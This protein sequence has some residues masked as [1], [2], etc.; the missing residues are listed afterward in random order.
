MFRLKLVLRL[1]FV[2]AL[3]AGILFGSA[4]RLDL[5]FF[6]AYL[7]VFAALGAVTLLTLRQDLLE[8]RFNRRARGRDNLAFLRA[9]ALTTFLAEWV[10]AGLDVGRLHVSDTIPGAVQGIALVSLAGAFGVWYWAMRVNP[11]FSPAVRVQTERGHHVVTTG[12]YA[13]VRHPG[14]AALTLLG[15]GGPLSL[16]SWYA[17]LPHLALAALFF[18]RAAFEDRMLHAELDGYADYAERVRFRIVPGIW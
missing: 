12:P 14:Y 15:L 4:G 6:W 7:G 5:P 3:V 8:E 9:A 17:A 18:R 2:L 10:L 13:F 1:A 11:F 16:G